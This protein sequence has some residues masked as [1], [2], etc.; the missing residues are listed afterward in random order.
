MNH[1]YRLIWNHAAAAWV[2]VAEIARSGGK[3]S[4][5]A[6]LA[7]GLVLAP[8]L[9]WGGGALPG[10]GSVVR[11][12]AAISQSG[13]HM[14]VQ[15]ASKNAVLNWNDFSIGKG[16]SVHFANGSGA[17]LNRVTG[18]LPSSIDGRLSATGS[19]YLV[20]RNG[21]IV[22]RDG[23]INAAGFMATTLDVPD[24]A[25]MA[26]QGLRFFGD[27]RAGIVNLG[28]IQADTGNVALVAHSVRN[29]GRI[30]APQGTA[31]LLAGQEVFLA[32][33]DA[34]GLLVS[35]GD[36]HGT[37]VDASGATGAENTGLIEAAQARM[38]AAN[39]NLYALAI[40]QSGVIHATG[41]QSKDGRIV[42][43]A[44]GG[45][46]R[47]D[48]QL[49]AHN[50]DGAGG[51]ILVGG[52]YQ[53]KADATVAN[54]SRTEVTANARMDASATA[55]RGD[56]GQV[57]VW[58]DDST[59]FA[60]RIAARGG[61]QG[62]DGGFAEVSGKRTLDFRPDAPIDL[63]APHGQTGT[64][65][66][67]PDEMTVVDTVTGPNQLAASAIQTALG[68]AN[69][70][71]NT[72]NFDPD[73]GSGNI[74]VNAD[75]AWSSANTLTLKAGNA[76]EIDADITASN[77][78]LEMYAG[79]A[80]TAPDE[81]SLGDVTGGA[82]LTA[83]HTI[84]ADRLRY[85]ANADSQPV[86]YTPDPD[87]YTDS[88]YADGNLHVGTL[89]LDLRG[90]E[91]GLETQGSNNLVN[92]FRT[93]GSGAMNWV[94]LTNHG[95][96]LTLNLQSNAA[97]GLQITTPGN[98]TLENGTQLTSTQGD[99][100]LASTGGNFINQAGASALAFTR[101]NTGFLVYTGSRANTIKGGLNGAAEFSRSYAGNPPDDYT[102]GASRFLY[103]EAYTPALLTYRA[104]D[105]ARLYN[106]ANPALTYTVSGLLGDD[107]LAGTVTGTPLLATAATQQSGVGQYA[108]T[109][110]QGTLASSSYGFQFVPGTLTIQQAPITNLLTYRADD[111]SRLYD[112]ANPALTYTV[113]GLQNGD[114]LHNVVTGAPLLSTTATQQSGVG[115]YAIT[116]SQGTLASGSY[117][118]QFVPGTLTITQPPQ[119]FQELTYRA[120]NLS[121]A[122]GHANPLL[123]YTVSGL[124]NG[125]ALQ[126]VVTGAPLLTT[127]ATQ[128]SGVGQYAITISQGTL[129]S[130]SYGFQFIPGTL[131]VN[132]APVIVNIDSF[133]R[134][135]GA[136][137]PVFS[138]T[139][140]GLQNGDTL[141]DAMAGF[142]LG[143]SASRATGVGS[144][145]IDGVRNAG[146]ANANYSLSFNPGTLT[147]NPTPVTLTLGNTSMVYGDALPDF[148]NFAT[149]T[150]AYNGDNLASAYP[151]AS[152][153][154]L[155]TSAY[156][157]G[158]YAVT[159]GSGFSNPNYVLTIGS[160]G[161]LS[162]TKAPLVIHANNASRYYGDANPAFTVASATGWKNGDTLAAIPDLVL[163][164][165]ATAAS[166]VGSYTIVPTGRAANYELVAGSGT[167]TVNK[168][169]VDVYLNA[170]SRYYGD[171]D[172]LFT[173]TYQGLKNGET[174]L[175]GLAPV[176]NTD[177]YSKV[178][179][180][181][182]S[183]G[184]TTTFQNYSPTFYAGVLTIAPRPLLIDIADASRTYGEANPW[185][186][187]SVSG[188][189]EW[190]AEQAGKYFAASTMATQRSD[191]GDYLIGV[192]PSG[193]GIGFNNLGNYQLLIN[194]GIL[195][196]A[197]APITVVADPVSI[198]WGDGLPPWSYTV[199]GFMP[200]D[201]S[202]SAG[203]IRLAS[204]AE[205]T[206]AQPG[207]YA[208]TLTTPEVGSNYLATLQGAPYVDV[209]KRQIFL[210]GDYQTTVGKVTDIHAGR[211]GSFTVAKYDA[212]GRK[213]MFDRTTPLAE[214]PQ[215]VVSSSSD[216]QRY[217][218]NGNPFFRDYESLPFITPIMGSSMDDVLRYYDPISI[219]GVA[220]AAVLVNPENNTIYRDVKVEPLTIEI[221]KPAPLQVRSDWPVGENPNVNMMFNSLG[222][223]PDEL[224]SLYDEFRDTGMFD[225]IGQD[226]MQLLR[227]ADANEKAYAT[228]KGWIEETE[229]WIA[230][231][232]RNKPPYWEQMVAAAEAD[233][234]GW[235]AEMQ[236]NPG[237]EVLRQR[238]I[239]GDPLALTAMGPLLTAGL[240]KSMQ[241]GKLPPAA[242]AQMLEHINQQRADLNRYVD[243]K[244][245]AFL[246]KQDMREGSLT[247]LFSGT[248]MP[249]IVGQAYTDLAA[250]Q[251]AKE[252]TTTVFV[253]SGV[254]GGIV[255]G[256][257][258]SAAVLSTTIVKG[259]SAYL[260]QLIS[261]IGSMGAAVP[262]AIAGAAVVI[263]G[264]AEGVQVVE[265][266]KNA[267][268]YQSFKESNKPLENLDNFDLKN[269]DNAMQAAQAIQA[270]VLKSLEKSIVVAQAQEGA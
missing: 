33:P 257:A 67:D 165:S 230:D 181:V 7:A 117:G 240:M 129:A 60:G 59:T 121:R 77:G 209:Q 56:G 112:V 244:Y 74:A 161:H 215:F 4:S 235:R 143:T 18:N 133:T 54:A 149:L 24:D 157:V 21:V 40:N 82:T 265:T 28:S 153:T 212:D 105:L 243:D 39:G 5:G 204:A 187:L 148:R 72:S 43:T 222:Q 52:S 127:T 138:A 116:I 193:D 131:T 136:A 102:D 270:L 219:P 190:D 145:A 192:A 229:A 109:I 42:L 14:Q 104:D 195:H 211:L 34:P 88:F 51:Q 11:G 238:A 258:V 103:R 36:A 100:V 38:Q 233:I 53:G 217:T 160:L 50:A 252:M 22:G 125:D 194:P 80:A 186:H 110:G 87:A 249:D 69:Y 179:S 214:G 62:G 134:Y 91:T 107:T 162:I 256:V 12:Q 81:S 248:K 220:H 172:P 250:D 223:T 255:A 207:R 26:G 111:L 218:T 205:D 158:T 83:G 130:G 97:Y 64:V 203:K 196:I 225:A 78:A 170:A 210:Y 94:E 166:N 79:R 71:I 146:N 108:I 224:R 208:I 63:S 75:L 168:A 93:V 226:A 175:P 228:Y 251:A 144:Y 242:E 124:Q 85:G 263:I 13:S 66:L 261:S 268:R 31:E 49:A 151:T 164:S 260:G 264:V 99:I 246:A 128:Q 9:A 119:V 132:A 199:S 178:G 113:S 167:L 142:T 176:S 76:I 98:L 150:G 118:F 253:S 262:W 86:G 6:V 159:T 101:P 135:Y 152:F 89:E 237:L 213:W 65:L 202:N 10:G 8:A 114:V 35:L 221:E 216:G 58:A 232:K 44:D 197:R 254:A 61:A 140:S 227:D 68:S 156:P 32:S 182:I 191:A 185:L 200:W 245:D 266:E 37:G 20:N 122:Y 106:V 241:E 154:A 120:S 126:D 2:A 137:N 92:A 73:S 206:T 84:T 46:V 198:I 95:T 23:V 169:P 90:G 184:G 25:F 115:Q 269:K 48:G 247:T 16:A 17:T 171:A 183:A 201:D 57:I 173:A 30:A 96:D 236:K 141:A 267:L 47:Q 188:A 3:R 41:V 70:E 174:A 234:I 163:T 231:V 239:E 45:T 1:T 29:A 259:T 147:I 189:T 19:L 15:Q 155:A 27:S 139:A 55:A 123:A 177:K 180:H